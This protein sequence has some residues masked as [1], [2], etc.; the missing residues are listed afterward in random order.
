MK[1]IGYL[2][3]AIIIGVLP[4]R[5][6]AA[7]IY[8]ETAKNTISVGD[9]AIVSIKIN[10]QGTTINTVEGNI[11]FK[12]SSNSLSVQE[13]SL[14]NSAFGMWPRTPSLSSDGKVVSFVGG[15]PGG[16]NI[17]NATIFKIIVEAKKEG[18]VTISPQNI[19]AYANDGKGTKLP[20]LLGNLVINV[21]PKKAG[22]VEHDEWK[23]TLLNDTTV[24]E[25]FIIVAGQNSTIFE[26]KKFVFFS[27]LD[28]Q[29]GISYY[30]VSE[31]GAPA[32]RSGSTYVL[33][34]QESKVKLEV[35]AY[36]KAGNKKIATYESP[37]EVYK[38]VLISIVGLV[39]LILVVLVF[40]KKRKTNA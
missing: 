36:D 3:V 1:T 35:T 19:V 32:V 14:A 16:F 9:T 27:A 40:R 28:N 25:D 17:E 38:I 37:V 7:T 18:S 39:V 21:V 24:P 6:S 2:L 8:L 23:T 26:G 31:N 4:L 12:S 13:F 5:A 34:D 20:V 11:G 22:A 33:K 15:V 30:E 10:A 29:S